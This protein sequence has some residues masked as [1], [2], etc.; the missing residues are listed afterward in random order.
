MVDTVHKVKLWSKVQALG[1]LARHLHLLDEAPIEPALR[2]P[3]FALPPRPDG[4][5]GPAVHLEVLNN[6]NSV[7]KNP[8]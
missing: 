3:L 5:W 8:A 4:G 6:P 2:V 1:L 7:T